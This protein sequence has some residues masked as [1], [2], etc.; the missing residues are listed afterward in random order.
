MEETDI[1][2][3]NAIANIQ[4]NKTNISY[5]FIG[6]NTNPS[7]VI[8]TEWLNNITE[9]DEVYGIEPF[10]SAYA[11]CLEFFTE[12][13]KIK[14]KML[15]SAIA[16]KNGVAKLYQGVSDWKSNTKTGIHGSL[17][18]PQESL[19]EYNENMYVEVSTITFQSFVQMFNVSKID[20]L[21]I[22]VEGYEHEILKQCL[23]L[24][25]NPEIIYYED[26]NMKPNK[27]EECL[28]ML[29]DEYDITKCKYDNLCLLK[30]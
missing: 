13:P 12:F 17:I 14:A 9:N 8:N 15:N 3:L 24:G 26:F 19:G 21:V 11:R 2:F 29:S 1:H 25:F 10:P 16:D 22:D 7:P 6:T 30:K 23:A 28:R 18:P 27:K 5:V 4:Q 20:V